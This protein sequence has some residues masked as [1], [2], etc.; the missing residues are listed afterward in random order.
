MA[1]FFNGHS[2]I[3]EKRPNA[4]IFHLGG[5]VLANGERLR[6]RD[7]DRCPSNSHRYGLVGGVERSGVRLLPLARARAIPPRERGGLMNS[8]RLMPTS[9]PGLRLMSQYSKE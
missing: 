5:R 9:L 3:G 6:H 8:R 4:E 1:I 2:A 7:L